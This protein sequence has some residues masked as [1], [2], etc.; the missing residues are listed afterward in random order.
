MNSIY[1]DL[2]T[3]VHERGYEKRR[4][5]GPIRRLTL[6]QFSRVLEEIGMAA[7]HGD[8]RTTTIREIE[9]HCKTSGLAS[10]LEDFQEGAKAGVTR[11]LAAFF[12]RQYGQRLSGDATFVF[13]HKSFGE[14]FAARRVMRAIER[15]TRELEGR[16]SSPD[17]GW[18][19]R[20][21]LKHWARICGPT[22][23]T[24]S[25]EFTRLSRLDMII[26]SIL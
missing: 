7:W 15:M 18:D 2:V 3:A 8:G 22:S 13:T 21:A 9:E 6:D 11:L 26:L 14:Y 1:A 24:L 10:M 23:R 12:F 19:E 17:E 16:T 5:Y 25:T 4:A 20:D